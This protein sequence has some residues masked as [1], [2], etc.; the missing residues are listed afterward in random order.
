M[1]INSTVFISWCVDVSGMGSL[2]YLYIAI[3]GKSFEQVNRYFFDRCVVFD[4]G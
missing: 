2:V 4:M 3:F 1:Y